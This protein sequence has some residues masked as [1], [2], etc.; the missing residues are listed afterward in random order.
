[1]VHISN[2]L[3]KRVNNAFNV[4]KRNDKVKIK[5][6]SIIGN[7]IGLSMKDVD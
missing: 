1:M 7:K 5:V 4:V 6:I 2:M 3:D